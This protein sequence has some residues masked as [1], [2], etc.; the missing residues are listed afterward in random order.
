MNTSKSFLL[1][2]HGEEKEKQKLF[3]VGASKEYV[4]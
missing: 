1:E 2:N 3:P 4:A